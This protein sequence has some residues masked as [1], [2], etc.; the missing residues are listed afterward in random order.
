MKSIKENKKNGKP[1]KKKINTNF[2][3]TVYD[4]GM[5]HLTIKKIV[6]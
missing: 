3:C 4:Q 5:L 1:K 6:F 2:R